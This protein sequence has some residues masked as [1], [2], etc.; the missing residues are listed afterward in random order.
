MYIELDSCPEWELTNC[1]TQGHWTA[2][3]AETFAPFPGSAPTHLHF[4][5][6]KAQA[7][8]IWH[9]MKHMVPNTISTVSFKE[10]SQ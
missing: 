4:Y 1:I 8:A 2:A 9:T 6:T 3:L 5:C 10:T 7:K